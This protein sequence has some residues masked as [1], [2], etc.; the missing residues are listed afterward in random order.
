MV[1]LNKAEGGA[2]QCLPRD[3]SWL[4]IAVIMLGAAWLRWH[5]L[6]IPLE[7]DE[8]EYAYGGQLLLQGV[9]PYQLLYSMKLPGIY[10]AYALVLTLFGQDQTGVHLGLLAMNLVSIMMVSLLGRRLAGPVAG[11][12]AGAVFA[13]LSMGQPV[14]GVFANA[15]H[16]VLAPALAG[17]LT[18]LFAVD[19]KRPWLLLLSGVLLG[20]GVLVK[21][22]GAFFVVFA[23]CYLLLDRWLVRGRLA[24]G[25]RQGMLLFCAALLPYLLTCLLLLK[26]GVFP[27]FWFWT[28]QYAKAYASQVPWGVAWG[29]LSDR[30]GT[31]VAASPLLW[32]AAAV[33]CILV[34][35]VKDRQTDKRSFVVGFA[36]ASFLAVCPGL[37][38]RPHYFILLL[39]A[40]A[41]LAGVACHSLAGIVVG[42]QRPRQLAGLTLLLVA[43]GLAQALYQQRQFLFAFSPAQASTDTYWP[44]PFN[45]S[46]TIARFLRENSSPTD[47]IAIIGSEPQILFYS[48]R[49][50]ATGYIYMY[51]L[52][53]G[54]EFALEMQR[55]LIAEVEGAA[56]EYLLF[57]RNPLSWLQTPASHTMIYEWFATYVEGYQQVGLIE[58]FEQSSNYTWF[59]EV[60][61]QPATEYWI[62]VLRKKGTGTVK[63]G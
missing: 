61:R 20:M 26:A 62:E 41:V 29:N 15:E 59:P 57:V 19:S 39:P 58:T 9:P 48:G 51:P 23:V 31:I 6:D 36:I 1:F 11:I 38:F 63:G 34:A 45:E 21:Q 24:D 35:V 10:A 27:Q 8:G 56:P 7:R 33:G 12:G 52:M 32:L 60:R 4:G 50:S 25:L 30:A 43:L 49:R 17:L 22:H 28:V 5:L 53:E 3:W 16:F 40:A 18:L 13:L 44:N 54:H 37:F 46:L 55:R 2:G 47:T 14:Q 42:Q